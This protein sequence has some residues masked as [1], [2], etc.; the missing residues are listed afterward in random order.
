ML[1]SLCPAM[2]AIPSVSR[3]IRAVVAGVAAN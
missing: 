2:S 3:A 1:P